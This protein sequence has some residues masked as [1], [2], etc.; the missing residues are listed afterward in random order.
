MA[1]SV[2]E[3]SLY[4][5]EMSRDALSDAILMFENGTFQP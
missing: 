3:L 2:E 5:Y 4:R 1:G